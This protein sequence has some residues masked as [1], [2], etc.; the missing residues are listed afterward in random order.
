MTMAQNP[1]R[2]EQY[3]PPNQTSTDLAAAMDL[4]VAAAA[5]QAL[6][7][8]TSLGTGNA[9]VANVVASGCLMIPPLRA[10]LFRRNPAGLFEVRCRA[11]DALARLG[12]HFVLLDYLETWPRAADPVERLGD[13]A[14]LSTAAIALAKAGTEAGFDL[15]LAVAESGTLLR[16]VVWGLGHYRKRRAIPALLSALLEDECRLVAEDAL[17]KLGAL[18]RPALLQAAAG[19]SRGNESVSRQRRSA[20]RILARTP[21]SSVRRQI[22]PLKQD[23]DPAVAALARTISSQFCRNQ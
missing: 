16:G 14:V 2:S 10:I 4:S 5:E 22:E 23:N 21:T 8:M 15:L 12:A 6:R 19:S 18:A 20:L 13:D 17:T 11:V 7:A 1:K 3:C 9:A